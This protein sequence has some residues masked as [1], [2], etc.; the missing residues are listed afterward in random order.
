MVV[1]F[2]KPFERIFVSETALSYQDKFDYDEYFL[3]ST[4]DD[5]N[6]PPT[7]VYVDM[8]FFQFSLEGNQN[9]GE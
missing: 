3:I 4:R 6:I 8:P 1:S 2:H 5:Q 9:G 7:Y